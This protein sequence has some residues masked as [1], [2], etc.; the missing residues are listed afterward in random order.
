VSTRP[1]SGAAWD[2]TWQA[3]LG[4]AGAP[5]DAP[6]FENHVDRGKLEFLGDRLPRTGRA[7]E[8]GCG[9]ARLLSRVRKAT[10]IAAV[11]LDPSPQA[12]ALARRTAEALGAPMEVLRGDARALPFADASFDLVLSGGLLEH[13]EDPRPVLA[14]MVRVLR[15]GG[16]FYADVVPRRPSL[17]RM[18]EIPR[19]LTRPWL[20]PGVYESA[21]GPADYRRLLAALGCE[22]IAI[23]TAG[24]Y[25]PAAPAW[26][27]RRAG[28]LDGT[29]LADA[30]GWYFMIAARRG[31]SAPATGV[32]P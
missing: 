7:I 22:A 32:R 8:I 5:L 6:T 17:Y 14:E 15:P 23:R 18:R 30:L 26:L 24:V 29:P 9:S 27:A 19:M 11:G 4:A 20:L 16:T 12:L 25:P 1:R 28:A 3:Q 13:F 10:G 21:F 2:A 31:G